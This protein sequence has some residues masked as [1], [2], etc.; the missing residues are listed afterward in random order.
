[1]LL[2]THEQADALLKEVPAMMRDSERLRDSFVAPTL[3]QRFAISREIWAYILKMQRKVY[4]GHALSSA[5]SCISSLEIY[6][7]PSR[8]TTSTFPDI[9]FY[10][11]NP[12]HD[13]VEICKRLYAS[14]M[15]YV[16]GKEAAHTGTFVISVEFTRICNVTYVPEVVY[17]LVPCT[18]FDS[19]KMVD[20]AFAIIDYLKILCDPFTSYWKLDRMMPRFILMQSLFPLRLPAVTKRLTRRGVKS[21]SRDVIAWA[22]AMP[23]I[24]AVGDYALDFFLEDSLDSRGDHL[25]LVTVNYEAD[26]GIFEEIF[27]SDKVRERS[28]L[29]DDLGRSATFYFYADGVLEFAVTL[30][31]SRDKAVPISGISGVSGL[32]IA[33]LSYCLLTSLCQH[34]SARV[35]NCEAEANFHAQTSAR[36][37]A[38]RLAQTTTTVDVT[39]KF[40]DVSLSYI[41]E[42]KSAMRTHM[43][44]TDDRRIKSAK[45]AQVWF[46]FD[47]SRPSSQGHVS[48]YMLLKCD[49]MMI[50]NPGD[51]V[52]VASR[53]SKK[54]SR[55]T[56]G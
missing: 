14:G 48:S 3:L 41:G 44:A 37:V 27:K 40:R 47:P 13:V 9:D 31:D 28:Q 36:L 30:I 11:P 25:T 55:V 32:R 34:M 53:A 26:A 20:P 22:S 54:M 10:S 49:G 50:K 46:S 33:S 12:I 23:S 17:K 19:I 42:P 18:I 16:Q 43:A 1:M 2:Y 35:N 15:S 51:S 6:D 24:A 4:G 7:H 5:L 45:N 8:W 52:L 29:L 21:L 39:S 56:S 38:M